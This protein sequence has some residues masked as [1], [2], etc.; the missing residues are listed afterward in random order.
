VESFVE[1]PWWLLAD[2]LSRSISTT[3]LLALAATAFLAALARGF[4]GFGSALIFIPLASSA[5]GPREAA[6]LLLIVDGILTL[7][8]I[9]SAWRLADR[10]EVG[11]MTLGTVA[12]VPLGTWFLAAIDPMIIRWAIVVLAAL[13][14]TLLMSGWRYH[15]KPTTTMTV[16]VGGLAGLSSG[17]AQMGGPPVVA[18]WLGGAIAATTVRANLILFFAISTVVTLITYLTAGLLTRSTFV[19]ALATG[20]AYGLGLLAGSRLFGFASET[21]F[22][23]TCYVLI[24]AAIILGLPAMDGIMR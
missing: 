4:S 18:Y 15:G 10:R 11:V 14:L 13:L 1:R 20:P 3:M 2:L 24:A 23:Q 5:V 17:A 6:P 8:F 22:R 16:I 12:G 7:G 21:T 19:L 9:P